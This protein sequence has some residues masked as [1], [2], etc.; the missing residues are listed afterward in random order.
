MLN[1]G[2]LSAFS[3]LAIE[4]LPFALFLYAISLFTSMAGMEIFGL[5]SAALVLFVLWSNLLRPVEQRPPFPTLS[6]L[7]GALIG[8]FIVVAVGA[9]V[10]SQ[11]T[12]E[13]VTVVGATRW[14]FL[15]LLLRTGLAWIWSE[16]FSMILDL[17][18]GVFALLV[19]YSLIQHFTGFDLVRS[20]N[21]LAQIVY[22]NGKVGYKVSALFSSSVTWGHVAALFVGFPA[23]LFFLGAKRHTGFHWYLALIVSCA[24]LSVVL[25][26]SFSAWVALAAAL[27]TVTIYS[28]RLAFLGV[29]LVVGAA[30]VGLKFASLKNETLAAVLAESGEPW[31][32]G[33]S[34][35]SKNPVIGSLSKLPDANTYLEWLIASGALGLA[36]YLVACLAWFWLSQKMWLMIP[37]E[38]AIEK[39]LVLGV[40]SAQVA[41]HV[42]GL[43]ES[44]FKDAEINHLFLFSL[45]M[46]WALY[47][48]YAHEHG[49]RIIRPKSERGSF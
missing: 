15:F 40:I 29:A 12:M 39:A 36:F 10:N 23:A 9:F 43:F 32:E 7:D 24:S 41:L 44:N 14:I 30:S 11:D 20:S 45:A 13:T 46:L 49:L 22:P 1:L 33:I 17:L 25:T 19:L 26:Y 28:N 34:L 27:L 21:D 3:K 18:I 5:V 38:R 6:I 35:W 48:H 2:S 16:N 8:L 4:A 37:R 31:N 47:N 42:S